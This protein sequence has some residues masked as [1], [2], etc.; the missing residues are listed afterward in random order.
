M[1]FSCALWD[2]Y[3]L[4]AEESVRHVFAPGQIIGVSHKVNDRGPVVG[5]DGSPFRHNVYPQGGS[6]SQMVDANQMH[7]F[8]TIPDTG[9]GTAVEGSSWGRIK[10]HFDGKLR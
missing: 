8:L 10:A 4:S 5:E 9:G 7:D 1:E 2:N 3:S 6:G